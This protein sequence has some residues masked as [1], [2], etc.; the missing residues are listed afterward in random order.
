MLLKEAKIS[1]KKYV[2]KVLGCYSYHIITEL[3]NK[4]IPKNERDL[5]GLIYQSF[6]NEGKKNI[7]GS[8]YTPYEITKN[9]VKNLNFSKGET[10][11]DPCCGSGA[12][13]LALENADPGVLFGTDNDPCAVFICKINLLIKYKD[14]EFEPQ[15]FCVDYLEGE[16]NLVLKQKYDY[17]I[18]NPPWG[19]ITDKYI[20]PSQINSKESFS[21]FFVKAFKQLK[22]NGCIRFLLPRSV[23]NV[24]LHKDIRGFMLNNG[25]LRK[26]TLYTS[27]FT[28]VTTDY[29][30]IELKAQ[31]PE[32]NVIVSTDEK[33]FFV[34]KKSFFQTENN[35][36]SLLE[37]AD[38][39]I[40]NKVKSNK[41]STLKNSIWALGIVTGNNK[42][43]LKDIEFEN[44][45]V[46]YTGKEID[47][48]KLKPAKKY[49]LYNRSQLQQV[50]KEEYYRAP[51]KLVYKFIS[52]KLVFAYDNTGSLFLNS[53]NILIPKI[54]TMSIKTVMAFLNSELFRYLYSRMFGEIK[55]LKG[56]LSQLPFPYI[57]H[58]TDL[59]ISS[60]V[61]DILNGKE[62]FDSKLQDVIYQVFNLDEKEIVHIKEAL[63]GKTA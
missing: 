2:K 42:E 16:E 28:G 14:R 37:E 35:V 55:V 24:K 9:M 62:A 10:F 43:K 8:Y 6:L 30:D 1:D 61:D 17:I 41:H 20:M 38:N 33:S 12:Y 4:E 46:I 31:E 45:E 47:R 44:S 56:N 53:A 54:D 15:I 25:N 11:F 57:S 26:I 50:A 52:N 32:K 48:Y 13:F 18:T 63:Y 58:E 23:L 60:L 49:I 59:Y 39:S 27:S 22:E 29:V 3:L 5:L 36:F 7:I 40:I 51:E 34:S 21:C 19:A